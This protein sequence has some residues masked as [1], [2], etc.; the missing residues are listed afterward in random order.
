[1]EVDTLAQK[2]GQRE[3]SRGTKQSPQ[4]VNLSHKTHWDGEN[5][6]FSWIFTEYLKT[7]QLKQQC[8]VES[9]I[10]MRNFQLESNYNPPAPHRQKR[11]KMFLKGLQW[12]QQ[13]P[14]FRGHKWCLPATRW[15]NFSLFTEFL[16]W[17]SSKL[18]LVFNISCLQL[19]RYIRSKM[20]T[21]TN[22][23]LQL[24]LAEVQWP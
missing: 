19:N 11:F 7:D 23:L 15:W 8:N 18:N 14:D 24:S 16:S 1:M 22:G 21:F 12:K 10:H 3:K 5:A 2:T 20:S 6:T 4:V 9:V 17:H 13:T